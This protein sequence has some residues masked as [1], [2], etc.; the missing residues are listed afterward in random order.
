MVA[1]L[2]AAAFLI[3]MALPASAAGPAQKSLILA[4]TTSAQDSRL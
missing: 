4:T 2:F 1:V 3:G